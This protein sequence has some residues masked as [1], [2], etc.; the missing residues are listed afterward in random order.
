MTK[1]SAQWTINDSSK[2]YQIPSWGDGYF[3][4]ND[5]GNLCVYPTKDP[6]G[7]QINIKEV[8][9]EVKKE[10]L[11]FPCVVRF[12]DILRD[13][14]RDLNLSFESIIKE[15][16]YKGEYYGVYPIKVNQLREVVEEIA[17]AG[18]DFN[19]G[20]EAGSK[21]ELMAVL[22]YN[23][24]PRALTILNG[25]KDEQYMKLA[26]LGTK[27]GRNMVIVIEKFSEIYQVLKMAEELEVE[28]TIG[29]RAKLSSKASGKWA[30]S[31]GDFAKFGLSA[32]EIVQLVELLKTENKLHYL[33]LFHYHV[34]SQIPDIRTIKDCLIEGAHIY[35]NLVRMGA[36][37]EYFD[38]GGGV[39]ISY[40]GSI[41]SEG[42]STNYTL[43][44]YIADVVYNIKEICDIHNISHPN[45][46]TETGRAVAAHH[47]CVITNVFGEISMSKVREI[48]ITAKEKDHRLVKNIKTLL[49]DL[50][51][52][53]YY[54]TYNDAC[55]L[56]DEG[57]SAF[58]LGV[59]N[60]IERS[61]I[62]TVYWNICRKIIVITESADNV[63]Q[64]IKQLKKELADKYLCNFSLFQSAP[65][66][67]AIDQVFPIVPI[68]HLDKQ[69]NTQCTLADITCDSDGKITSFISDEGQ[70][71]TLPLHERI[72]GEDYFIGFFLT[73]AYQ[74]VM[75]DMHNLFGRLNEVHIYCDDDDPT[76]FYIEEII[77]GNSASEV[78]QI[79][80]YDINEMNRLIKNEVDKNIKHGKIKPR[81]GVK[82]TDFYEHALKT[83]TYLG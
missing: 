63:P 16:D 48:D 31:S 65:D 40:D 61:E 78:L 1:K 64:E 35:V 8:I 67:W 66:H 20:L 80:Q 54:D 83:Y 26:M 58:K 2:L 28:P 82:L 39:G 19:Y 24:N 73:G 59:L 49:R 12:H 11:G 25:Y 69:P 21:P 3:G 75:G 33:K 50:N 5:Q 60:L 53:N 27:I 18:S 38:A 57:V 41:S 71:S 76:D 13:R 4:I 52:S 7:P 74:D 17:D 68:S 43:Q 81:I 34:G 10:N 79:M 56:K 23:K 22:A 32:P 15:A 44:E 72:P 46:V 37:L 55:I 30:E 14:V 36:P 29:V 42:S 77:N 6:N 9:D 51:L 47:S 70:L 45:I 62:E